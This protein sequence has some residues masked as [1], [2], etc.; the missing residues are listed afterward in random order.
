MTDQEKHGPNLFGR[1]LGLCLGIMLDRTLSDPQRWHPVA[2]FGRGAAWLEKRL[3]RDSR[4]A[5]VAFAL[6]A[7]APV[8]G[9]ATC[10][11]RASKRAMRGGLPRGLTGAVPVALVTWTVVGG[12]QLADTGRRMA[13]LLELG[14]LDGARALLPHLCGRLPNRLDASELARATVES[15]AENTSDALTGSLVWGAVLGI[16][17]LVLH[18]AANTLD[19]MVGHRSARYARFGTA[20]ARLDDVVNLLPARATGVLF[21]GLAPLV[22]GRTRLA[23]RVLIRDH[24]R[25]PSPNGG[26]CEAAMAGALGVRL[27]GRNVY[28]G[29]RVEERPILGGENRACT[30][31]DVRRAARLVDAATLTA[32]ALVAVLLVGRRR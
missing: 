19:A 22:D 20:S 26:W 15:L 5:G 17:G 25:H 30:A 16:P 8:V 21:A 1:A 23:W 14:D 9:A 29:D 24:S 31:G 6:V 11:E 18:R 7:L 27:G 28:P 2:G 10:A 13:D 4:V 3:W 32:T 12:R